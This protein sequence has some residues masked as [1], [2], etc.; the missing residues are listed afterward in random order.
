MKDT[1]RIMWPTHKAKAAQ[2]KAKKTRI[3][4]TKGKVTTWQLS[5]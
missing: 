2:R 4:N 5:K 1:V 3:K